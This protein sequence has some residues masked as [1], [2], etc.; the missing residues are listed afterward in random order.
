M[1]IVDTVPSGI[2]HGGYFRQDRKR[3]IN[4]S[5]ST[6]KLPVSQASESQDSI[7]V[8]AQDA[9]LEINDN[10]VHEYECGMLGAEAALERDGEWVWIRL[11]WRDSVKVVGFAVGQIGSW[12]DSWA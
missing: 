2:K 4:S 12:K 11:L 9:K 1:P 6:R 5:C 7:S 10:E 8:V 3:P